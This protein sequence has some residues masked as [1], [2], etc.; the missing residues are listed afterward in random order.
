M[1]RNQGDRVCRPPNS[2][3]N[4]VFPSTLVANTGPRL[5]YDGNG[6]EMG[7][8]FNVGLKMARQD[9]LWFVDGEADLHNGAVNSV[10]TDFLFGLPV[11][12]MTQ[13]VSIWPNLRERAVG[14]TALALVHC[15]PSR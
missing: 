11:S 14:C 1:V 8:L 9:Q 10:R 7:S 6:K 2:V 3:I 4:Y 15:Y 13:G 5:I 12:I